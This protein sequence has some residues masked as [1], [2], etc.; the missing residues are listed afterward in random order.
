MKINVDERTFNIAIKDN[1]F[2]VAEFL[3]SNSCPVNYLSYFQD[4]KISTLD[5]LY[6]KGIHLDKNCLNEVIYKI[7]DKEI[8]KWYID[9]GLVTDSK[10]LDSC[11]TNNHYELFSWFMEKYKVKPTIDNFIS[12]VLSQDIKFLDY[13]N[14]INCPYD[15]RLVETAIKNSKKESIKWL[16]KN[17][18]F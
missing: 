5:W 16:V 3:L 7:Q 11:I 6:S 9:K 2:E 4:F 15:E 14:K 10:C 12:A 17:N 8:I 13:L 1:K 18:F